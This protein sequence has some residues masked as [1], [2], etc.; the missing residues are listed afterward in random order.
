MAPPA[1]TV[2]LLLVATASQVDAGGWKTTGSV[3]DRLKGATVSAIE[4]CYTGGWCPC[5]DTTKGTASSPVG[6]A[7]K[8]IY[9][10]LE[11]RGQFKFDRRSGS[12]HVS[13]KNMK[14][15]GST[16]TACAADVHDGLVDVCIS[17]FWE[18]AQR[19]NM[20]PFTSPFSSDIFYLFE[21]GEARMKKRARV[22][23]QH[24]CASTNARTNARAGTYLHTP[25]RMRAHMSTRRHACMPLHRNTRT[26]AP[27]IHTS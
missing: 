9:T 16:W 26:H 6:G 1:L 18:T 21:K 17:T 8:E 11:T 10:E 23:M 24:A 15:Y 7:L 12:T 25:A 22:R 20:T 2:R 5:E 3:R 19:R 13:K 14:A 27:M 4:L